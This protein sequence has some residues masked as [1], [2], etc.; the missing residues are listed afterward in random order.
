[1]GGRRR[2]HPASHR[3]VWTA[4]VHL[5][6]S[7]GVHITIYNRVAI[8]RQFSRGPDARST[9]AGIQQAGNRPGIRALRSI[10]DSDATI[11]DLDPQGSGNTKGH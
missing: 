10:L 6:N 4:G 8:S 3:T 11:S 1:M 5:K 7:R 2:Q 9:R